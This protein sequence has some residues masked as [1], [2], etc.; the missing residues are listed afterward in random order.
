MCVCRTY[1][2]YMFV[3]ALRVRVARVFF[4]CLVRVL[5]MCVLCTVCAVRV[6]DTCVHCTCV[7]YTC[8]HCSCVFLDMNVLI[9]LLCTVF[10][11]LGHRLNFERNWF[12]EY[13]SDEVLVLHSRRQILLSL[14]FTRSR[15]VVY[16]GERAAIFEPLFGSECFLNE[17]GQLV[18]IV[19]RRVVKF[20]LFG[21]LFDVFEEVDLEPLSDVAVTIADGKL[22]LSPGSYFARNFVMEVEFSEIGVELLAIP[23][24]VECHTS[25]HLWKLNLV[26][27][28]PDIHDNGLFVNGASMVFDLNVEG[29]TLSESAVPL[30]LSSGQITVDGFLEISSLL[31]SSLRFE[32]IFL[33]VAKFGRVG[34]PWVLLGCRA[35]TSDR[36]VTRISIGP[37]SVVGQSLLRTVGRLIFD[38]CGENAVRIASHT[39]PATVFRTDDLLTYLHTPNLSPS[40]SSTRHL[41]KFHSPIWDKDTLVLRFFALNSPQPFHDGFGEL[42][43]LDETSPGVVIPIPGTFKRIKLVGSVRETRFETDFPCGSSEPK[44]SANLDNFELIFRAIEVFDEIYTC[45]LSVFTKSDGYMYIETTKTPG[46]LQLVPDLDRGA[47][48]SDTIDP[49]ESCAVCYECFSTNLDIVQH[50]SCKNK[51]CN[52]CIQA[53]MKVKRDSGR[54]QTCPL[55]VQDIITRHSV[56]GLTMNEI[57]P[58]KINRITKNLMHEYDKVVQLLKRASLYTRSDMNSLKS[59]ELHK[60]SVSLDLLM[61]MMHTAEFVNYVSMLLNIEILFQFRKPTY[62][63]IAILLG[64]VLLESLSRSR[65]GFVTVVRI[66]RLGLAVYNST[67]P[68]GIGSMASGSTVAL[69]A[70]LMRSVLTVHS[71]EKRSRILRELLA[72]EWE[73]DY[74]NENVY[75]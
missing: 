40:I 74:P 33:D 37:V 24:H 53:W 14:D 51:F 36:C 54:I 18:D 64:L 44:F 43:F 7:R 1:V 41:P 31:N 35:G 48:I 5:Y 61:T 25:E 59:T 57:V 30:K 45:K 58:T 17:A 63:D 12:G 3:C 46:G 69:A 11:V 75:D 47:D 55:C 10:F 20:Y 49:D 4:V 32:S 56:R 26:P 22:G 23:R 2:L 39:K 34:I 21:V 19:K 60:I 8:L 68:Y 38:A 73:E 71:Q 70:L 29:I 66:F 6:C 15:S 13:V 9:Y 72:K 28:D 42:V 27:D 52:K 67:L 62:D 16:T 50:K 65:R